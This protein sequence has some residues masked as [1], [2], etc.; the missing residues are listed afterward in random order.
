MRTI[1]ITLFQGVEAKNILRTDIYKTLAADPEL[2]LVLFVR[3]PERAE[4]YRKEFSGRNV[5]YEVAPERAPGRSETFFSNLKFLL[6]R[7]ATVDLRRRMLLEE[8]GN[9][10]G[11][12]A[13]WL[14]NRMLA[15]RSVRQIVRRLDFHFGGSGLFGEFFDKY[16][17]DA[18]FLA[19]LFDDTETDLLR[20]AKRRGVPAVGFI[21]S[22]DKLT[23][24]G[25]M[26]LLPGKLIVFNDLVKEEAIRHAD[27]KAGDIFVAGIPQYDWHVNYPPMSRK[28]FCAK[29][30]LDPAKKI[31]VYAPMGKTYSNSDW[32]I[33]DLLHA[34]ISAGR[35]PN[36]QLL[37][38]FQP[39][40][41]L[42]ESE[43]RKRSYLV[44][45]RPGIRF[46]ST[47]GVDWDM[48]F[49]DIR[50]LTDTLANADLFI[51]YASSMSIDAAVF[52]KPVI[53]IDFEVK[54]RQLLSKSPTHFYQMTHYRNAVNSGGIAYPRSEEELIS[55][56]RRYLEHPE[57]D[58][59]GRARL[60][61]EQCGELDGH[62]G[63]RIAGFLRDSIA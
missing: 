22:W 20:E 31:I 61:R 36:A 4:Y 6:L 7:T 18:V 27:M 47:R 11:Y 35:I 41:F 53:N 1:F 9:Y 21:N 25:I 12:A 59:E 24:R 26:R 10:L 28:D 42:D 54:E 44:Y 19:H 17:P 16:S 14:L 48:S 23:A 43:L 45:D 15:R 32:D 29:K 40:D 50:G 8:T 38:R 5:V 34:A 55:Q 62:A 57:L 33:V 52:H 49:D 56:I 39:N 63:Q 30:G 51:C 13:N 46:S 3:T 60:V 2:R 58:E 37:V